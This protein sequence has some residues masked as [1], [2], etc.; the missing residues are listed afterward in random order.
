[1]TALTVAQAL[2]AVYESLKQDNLDIDQHIDGLKAA[3]KAEGKKE[4]AVEPARLAQNNRQGR[5]MMQSYFK[6][7]GVT[8]TFTGEKD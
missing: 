2:E 1:M 8:V 6:K 7:R 5:K 3:L 4:V